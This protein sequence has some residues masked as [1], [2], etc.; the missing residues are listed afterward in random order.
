MALVVDEYGHFLGIATI[1]DVLEEIVGDI[2]DESDAEPES[3]VRHDDGSLELDADL[4]LRRVAALLNVGWDP[5][6]RSRNVNGLVTDR[7]GRLPRAG[8]KVKWKGHWIEVLTA[9]DRRAEKVTIRRASKPPL[10]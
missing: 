3:F 9:T 1:E 10:G 8:D 2:I 6:E 4:E 5:A 7:L